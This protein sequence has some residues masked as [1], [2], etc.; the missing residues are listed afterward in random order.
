MKCTEYK[1]KLRFDKL[2]EDGELANAEMPRFARSEAPLKS[3]DCDWF[4]NWMT[5]LRCWNSHLIYAHRVFDCRNEE[6]YFMYSTVSSSPLSLR[7]F[8]VDSAYVSTLSWLQGRVSE[9]WLLLTRIWRI[10][11]RIL[12][13]HVRAEYRAIVE[14]PF[15]EIKAI[16]DLLW[17]E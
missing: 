7:I 4:E 14:Q 16:V 17:R 5:L 8:P 2:L 11:V 10:S 6:E 15:V 13:H 12:V 9:S 1:C 3:G